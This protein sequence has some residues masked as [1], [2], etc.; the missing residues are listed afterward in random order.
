[1]RTGAALV[2]TVIALAAPG[3]ARATTDAVSVA[4]LRSGAV[5]QVVLSAPRPQEVTPLPGALTTPLG[6]V[7]KLFVHVYLADQ[8]I[9]APDY[10]CGGHHSSEEAFCCS[11]GGRI[12]AG[13][14]LARS[15]GLF[16]DPA[17]LGIT[18]EEWRRY[19]SALP[20]PASAAWLLDLSR[21][22]PGTT[23]SVA[24]LLEA[25]AAIP[26]CARQRSEQAL[27]DVTLTGRPAPV[28][29]VGSLLR[30]K[31]WTWDDP[32]RSDV[33]VGGFA[34][35]V[36][37]GTPVWAR[38]TGAGIA[39]LQRAAP[40]LAARLGATIGRVAETECVAVA[41]FARY[42][43]RQVID[44][45]TGEAAPSGLLEGRYRVEFQN[46]NHRDV[47]SRGELTLVRADTLAI[48]GRFGLN[49]Y[50]ARVIDREA[51]ATPL[52][53]A[54][55]LAVAIRTYV[56]QNGARVGGCYQIAD[57]SDA[58]RVSPD[59]PTDA[60]RR[61]AGWTDSLVLRGVPLTYHQTDPGPDRLAWTQAVRLAREGRRFDEILAAAYPGG[62]LASLHGRASGDCERLAGAER[63]LRAR[64]AAWRQRLRHEPGFEVPRD[65][66]AVCRL[67]RTH[68]YTDADRSRLYVRGIGTPDDRIAV[69]HEYLHLGFRW[70]PRGLDEA[71]IERMARDLAGE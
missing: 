37:D 33:R 47:H 1:M 36:A 20:V 15:C 13:E 70:H 3:T 31:T 23:V 68:P 35:W 8:G 69:A 30:V 39:V 63:W 26:P 29:H 7:W 53:A 11:P 42:P 43:L 55:A 16:F 38:G 32:E 52:E 41:F 67:D 24:S 64:A 66:L 27:L 45:R 57:T 65:D 21:L 34:G 51:G 40:A 5:E 19:W 50:V 9:P 46:G 22:R 12:G 49:E 6:S 44:H 28:R 25:L 71:L 56:I 2:A 58:Q 60:A 48:T 4:W 61:V 62:T 18:E 10:A 14:A 54:R 17:R 59:P